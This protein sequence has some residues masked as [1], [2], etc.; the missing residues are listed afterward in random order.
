MAVPKYAGDRGEIPLNLTLTAEA[1]EPSNEQRRRLN[2]AFAP[3]QSELV[4][5]LRDKRQY[6]S[7]QFKSID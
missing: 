4:D 1:S 7:S 3:E 2:E 5:L 6:A